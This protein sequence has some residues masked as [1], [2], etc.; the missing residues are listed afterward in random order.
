[1]RTAP[2]LWAFAVLLL[3]LSACDA[4]SDD[5]DTGSIPFPELSARAIAWAETAGDHREAI[6]QKFAYTCPGNGTLHPI[7]GVDEYTDDS[8]ICTAAVHAGKISLKSGGRVVIE[9]RP[10]R[11]SYS[12]STRHGITSEGY[13]EWGGGFIFPVPPSQ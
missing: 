9:M 5:D 10:G 11:S 2:A 4:A 6:G 7:W 8:S 3:F 12:G 13:G 1:M